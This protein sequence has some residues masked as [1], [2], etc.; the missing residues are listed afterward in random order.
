MKVAQII[1]AFLLALL[2]GFNLQKAVLS[3]YDPVKYR[4]VKATQSVKAGE[5][6]EVEI[7]LDRNRFCKATLDHFMRHHS[8]LVVWKE[9]SPGGASDLGQHLSRIRYLVPPDSP[10]GSYDFITRGYYEC[11]EGLH[12]VLFPSAKFEVTQ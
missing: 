6:I 5:K 7:L 11:E 3:M 10:V 1:A 4:S 12:V 9:S 8:G 2:L